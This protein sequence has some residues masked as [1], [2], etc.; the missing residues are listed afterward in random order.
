MIPHRVEPPHAGAKLRTWTSADGR[1]HVEAELVKMVAGVVHLKRKDNGQV[2]QVPVDKLSEE[3]Q[4][5]LRK[6]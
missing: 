3:D 2:I 5:F 6:R 4:K 1:F